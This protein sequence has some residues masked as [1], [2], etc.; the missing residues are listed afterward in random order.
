VT[1]KWTWTMY[2]FGGT[3]VDLGDVDG[4]PFV[5]SNACIRYQFVVVSLQER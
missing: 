2:P 4:N 3:A 1:P 5:A